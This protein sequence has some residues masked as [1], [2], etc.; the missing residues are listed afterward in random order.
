MRCDL[1]QIIIGS[2]AFGPFFHGISAKCPK[3][4]TALGVSIDPASL[5]ADIAQQV[6]EKL[7][8]IG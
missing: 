2:Q 3:C 4:H 1:D 8:K 5:A 7:G 6:A